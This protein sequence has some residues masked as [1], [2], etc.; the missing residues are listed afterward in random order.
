[1]FVIARLRDE[2]NRALSSVTRQSVCAEELQGGSLLIQTS[3]ENQEEVALVDIAVDSKKEKVKHPQHKSAILYQNFEEQEEKENS[4]NNE[5]PQM[6][7]KTFE[8]ENDLLKMVFALVLIFV[9]C[10]IPYQI[11]FLMFE[12]QV[13]AFLYWPHRNTFTRL[14]FTLTCLPSALHPVCYGMMSKFITKRLSE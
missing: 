5:I 9:I 11:Q 6:N 14:V 13:E 8:L 4:T 7:N 2:Q 3:D 12:F 1:M 10:Y